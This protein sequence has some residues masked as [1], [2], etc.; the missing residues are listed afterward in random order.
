MAWQEAKKTTKR[1]FAGVFAVLA[2]YVVFVV[3]QEVIKKVTAQNSIIEAATAGQ[4]ATLSSD[5]CNPNSIKTSSFYN[6][7]GNY[8]VTSTGT[9]DKGNTITYT[10]EYD[11]NNEV[12]SRTKT[13]KD[14]NGKVTVYVWDENLYDKGKGGWKKTVLK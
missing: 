4:Q 13:V 11:N 1:V 9:D 2:V 12:V 10:T 6:D 3:V 7:K 5:G 8:V 14:K